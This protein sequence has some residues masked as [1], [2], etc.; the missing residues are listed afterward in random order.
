MDFF[1]LKLSHS[2]K[3]L[4]QF[5][6]KITISPAFGFPNLDE[7]FLSCCETNLGSTKITDDT[8]TLDTGFFYAGARSVISSL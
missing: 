6:I 5:F 1:L 4:S 2:K 7:I 3:Y 8:M